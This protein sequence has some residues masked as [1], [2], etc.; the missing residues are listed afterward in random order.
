MHKYQKTKQK[1]NYIAENYIIQYKYLP[2]P[3]N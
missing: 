1:D 2:L 3:I